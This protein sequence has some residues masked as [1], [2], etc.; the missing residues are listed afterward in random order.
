MRRVLLVV[1]VLMATTA[2]SYGALSSPAAVSCPRLTSAPTIDGAI[3]SGEWA[4][5]AAVGP[6]V[7][8]NGGMP[9][10]PTQAWIGYDSDALYVAARLID[11]MPLGAR[12]VATLHDEAV[13]ADDSL[14]VVLDP[15]NDGVGV[16]ELAV[17]AAGVEYDAI[18]GDPSKPVNWSS[19]VQVGED[20]WVVEIAWEFGAEGAPSGVQS[21][22]LDLRRNAPRVAERS[23][24]AGPMARA[25]MLVDGPALRCEL[26]PVRDPWYGE[27]RISVRLVNLT[28]AHQ[29]VKVNTRV[30]APTRRGHFFE[31]T[32]LTLGP[33]EARE[34]TVRY[35]VQRGGRSGVEVSVQ[36]VEGAS[37]ITALRTA[38]MGF[39]LPP[40][41]EELDRA[42]AHITEAYV[43]YAMLPE[44]A[45]PFGGASRLDMLLARWRYLD[46]QQQRKASSTVDVVMALVTR[47][48]TLADDAAALTAEL[49]SRAEEE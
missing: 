42:L 7:L 40:L 43:A 45:R 26:Q 23:S 39:E 2:V 20:G 35:L 1:G 21:W 46:S 22:G 3:D 18:D 14:T 16:I 48:R 34:L 49:T 36:V 13:M 30:T 47:A 25:T 15:G 11:P 29:T 4:R 12:C 10:L 41:G 9:A 31:V 37:A 28:N 27:N 6:F 38:N 44:D 8:R 32:K 33:D 5:A 24:M 19:A 17:N